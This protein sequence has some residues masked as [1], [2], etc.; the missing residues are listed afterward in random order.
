MV[1]TGETVEAGGG[2]LYKCNDGTGT[3]IALPPKSPVL[4]TCFTSSLEIYWNYRVNPLKTMEDE[5]KQKQNKDCIQV[6]F[7]ASC[8]LEKS[9]IAVVTFQMLERKKNRKNN[10]V[11][12]RCPVP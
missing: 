6:K 12:L 11:K 3:H 7:F 8:Q 2:Q 9:K 5:E 4:E 10:G 1:Y